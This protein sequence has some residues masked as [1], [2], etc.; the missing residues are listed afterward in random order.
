MRAPRFERCCKQG[1]VKL[2]A[3]REPPEYLR[4]LFTNDR[5]F[6]NK[7]RGYNAAFAFS[8]FIATESRRHGPAYNY[9]AYMIQGQAYSLHGPLTPDV[10][11]DQPPRYAQLY[12]FDPQEATEARAQAN[13]GLD[14]QVLEQLDAQIREVNPLVPIYRRARDILQ[15][16]EDPEGARVAI[17]RDL[18]IRLI[19]GEDQNVGNLP[20]ADEVAAL[21]PPN[22][23]GP[24][25]GRLG[26][27]VFLRAP[28]MGYATSIIS[29]ADPL[30][31][32]LCY[33]LFFPYAD[34]AWDY[35]HRLDTWPDAAAAEDAAGAAEDGEGDSDLDEENPDAENARLAGR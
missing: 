13:R 25:N 20:E 19:E 15:Q 31:W 8:S 30:H 16:H 28:P 32:A 33:P 29:S 24:A 27:R 10:A 7:I 34:R 22:N 17:G 1:R 14:R 4:N 5:D 3:F 35:Y 18:N 21:I 12:I 26:V 11:A 23:N 9:H 2:P 6:V